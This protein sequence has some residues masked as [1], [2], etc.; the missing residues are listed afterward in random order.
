MLTNFIGKRGVELFVGLGCLLVLSLVASCSGSSPS[1]TPTNALSDTAKTETVPALE[2]SATPTEMGAPISPEPSDA[3]P[4]VISHPGLN[5]AVFTGQNFVGSGNCA[6][7]HTALVDG[8]GNDVSIDTHWRSAMMANAAVDPL[9]QAKVSSEI[10]RN[11][12]LKD[13]IEDKCARCHTPMAH[14]R[15]SVDGGTVALFGNGFFN[16]ENPQ[17]VQAMDG[18]S[19]TLCHQIQDVELGEEASFSGGFVIDTEAVSPDRPIFGP[20]PNQF[21]QLMIS[22]VGYKPVLGSQTLDS[23]LCA[24]CHTLFTPYV[25]SSGKVLG[26]FPEQTPYLEW[27]NSSYGDGLDEDQACQQCHMPEAEGKVVISNMPRGGRLQARSPFVQ[28]HFVGGNAF[29]LKILQGGVEELELRASTDQFEATLLRTLDQLQNK[30]AEL[31]IVEAQVEND[32]MTLVLDVKNKTGHKLPTGFPT[33]SV[34][35]HLVVT[36]AEGQ[37]VFESGQPLPDG[38][39]AGNNADEDLKTYEPH[40]DVISQ[41]DQVQI[42]QTIMHNSD[43][44]VTYTLL[45]AASY[46]KDN[47]LLP[48]GF[49]KSS[50]SEAIA[51]WGQAIGDENFT[52]GSDQVRYQVDLQGHSGPFTVTA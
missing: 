8:A 48:D 3:L 33:R 40:Y 34:W 21:E 35:I 7:C 28:H 4:T 6:V 29:M 51:V 2:P 32:A 45:R 27:E 22:T 11:P 25:D 19:C 46:V 50:A 17:N 16:P 41:P 10:T 43:G 18:V 23:G 15:V 42:Y 37:M 14:T 44:A 38:S 26:E 49:D 52:G 36:D 9:W 24:A 47:R 5:L 12:G 31:T 30:T 39:I 20:F 1:P 13:V